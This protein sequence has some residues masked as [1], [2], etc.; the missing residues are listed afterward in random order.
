M[1]RFIYLIVFLILSISG[2]T[3]VMLGYSYNE[4]VEDTKECKSEITKQGELTCLTVFTAVDLNTYYIF[5]KENICVTVYLLP[6]TQGKLNFL[7]EN[8]NKT[9]VITSKTEWLWYT[10]NG[11][12]IPIALIKEKEYLVFKFN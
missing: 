2:Y 4:V 8:Y 12:I 9:Y 7:V 10:K 11:D 6:L 5:N 3:Q 1:K